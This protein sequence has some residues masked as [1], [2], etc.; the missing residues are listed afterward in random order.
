MTQSA[1]IVKWQRLR[2]FLTQPFR[3]THL[4]AMFGNTLVVFLSNGILKASNAVLFIL[5][6][7]GLGKDAAGR[8]SITTTYVAIALN[9]A[10]FGLDEILIREA[11][12]RQDQNRLF[13]NFLATRVALSLVA[14]LSL[15]LFLIVSGLYD[16]ALTALIVLF[17][18][19]M[20]GDGVLLLCQALFISRARVRLVFVTATAISV[21]RIASGLLVMALDGQLYQLMALFV[22]TSLAGGALAAWFAQDRILRIPPVT[23]L[24]MVDVREAVRWVRRSGSFF[25]IS[26]FVMV[27][28]QADVILLSILRTPADVALYSAALTIIIAA[29]ILPQAYR[30]VI[31]PQMAQALRRSAAEF[32]RFLRVTVG[33]AAFF[34]LCLA[35]G[36]ALL[37]R[38]I[39][40]LLY[41][42]G[43]S[44]SVAILQVLTIP[45]FF[46]FLSAPSSRAL[47][48]LHR[49]RSA[50]VLVGI[51]MVINVAGNLLLIPRYGPLGSAW[52][53]ALS[54]GA[55]CALSYLLLATLRAKPDGQ[56]ADRT[57]ANALNDPAGVR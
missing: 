24:K 7:N 26:L 11:A 34:G 32:W 41:P 35:G 3:G 10:L 46:A 52:A 5:V 2:K 39:I 22:L 53:R 30:T 48:T 29:W 36:L 20:V 12:R 45:L 19:G 9:L 47:L 43:Y 15:D 28:F 13:A 21:V 14:A 8:F 50:A 57:E 18:F 44:S 4:Q 31:Y 23:L 56:P 55:F 38:P 27:E 16:P 51:A 25:W 17:S 42:Q 54:G 49:E 33:P 1:Q 6:V 37:A 40:G